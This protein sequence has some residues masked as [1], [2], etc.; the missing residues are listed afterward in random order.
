MPLH[1]ANTDIVGRGK[2]EEKG[3]NTEFTG[4]VNEWVSKERKKS[5]H[6]WPCSDCRGLVLALNHTPH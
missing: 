5:D 2:V 1:P 4:V 3:L 6:R